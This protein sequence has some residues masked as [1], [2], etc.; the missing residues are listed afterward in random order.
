MTRI[1]FFF[2]GFIFLTLGITFIIL[3]LNIL[4]YEYN[5][6]NFVN[7]IFARVECYLSIIGL[8]IINL[9]LFLKGD[10]KHGIHL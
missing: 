3:Y 2:L 9:A 8:L 1:F 4:S 5:F 10:S 7:Y 6:S